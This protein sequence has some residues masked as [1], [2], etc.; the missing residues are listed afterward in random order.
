M[1]PAGCAP[2]KDASAG[3]ADAKVDCQAAVK[4]PVVLR[5]KAVFLADILKSSRPASRSGSYPCRRPSVRNFV[6]GKVDRV[7][8]D[9]EVALALLRVEERHVAAHERPAE[10]NGNAFR[11]TSLR[12]R[13][14]RMF[15]RNRIQAVIAGVLQVALPAADK[16]AAVVSWLMLAF[17]MPGPSI[18]TGRTW[19]RVTVIVAVVADMRFV[20]DSREK[21]CV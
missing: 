14:L 18:H 4:A 3:P 19:R 6:A 21:V 1:R 15:L 13:S 17:T 2:H 20:H 8:V 9:P 12:N 7:F 5:E 16:R 11:A 10:F